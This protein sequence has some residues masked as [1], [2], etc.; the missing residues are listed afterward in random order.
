M[1]AGVLEQA[2]V[3]HKTGQQLLQCQAQSSRRISQHVLHMLQLPFS[4]QQKGTAQRKLQGVI[5]PEK[6]E[7]SE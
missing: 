3:V 2:R 7:V 5:L 1:A 4:A 6:Q